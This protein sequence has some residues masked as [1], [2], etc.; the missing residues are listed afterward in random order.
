MADLLT[1]MIPFFFVLAIVYGA[2]DYSNVLKKNSV[3]A[4]ISLVIAF[5]ALTYQPL[6]DFIYAV[7]PYAV[8]LFIIVFF[9]AFIS[10]IFKGRG[11]EGGKGG[12]RDWT[13]IA[14]I[15][16]LIIILI[17]AY[18]EDILISFLPSIPVENFL[19][20]VGLVLVI[21]IFYAAYQSQKNEKP[22]G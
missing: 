18:G 10:K 19:Y 16:I 1:N 7:L 20:A 21:L 9:L 2:L 12:E 22:A 11:G 3:K 14:I 8:I 13:L 5:F 4:M 15:V 17:A 6:L